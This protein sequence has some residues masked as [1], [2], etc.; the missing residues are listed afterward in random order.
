M[1]RDT[2]QIYQVRV[3]SSWMD[4]IVLFLKE[5]ILPEEKLEANKIRR[6]AP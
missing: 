2:V 3:G 1:R 4:P 5:D 6:K